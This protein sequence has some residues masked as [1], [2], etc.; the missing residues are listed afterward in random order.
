MKLFFVAENVLFQF[1]NISEIKFIA[2]T[3]ENKNK[4][5]SLILFST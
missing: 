4:L 1:Q 5:F 3:T 2:A